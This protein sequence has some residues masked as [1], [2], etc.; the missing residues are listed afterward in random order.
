[1]RY[2]LTFNAAARAALAGNPNVEID[3]R[4]GVTPMNPTL[5]V[6][7]TAQ[8]ANGEY[9]LPLQSDGRRIFFQ[10]ARAAGGAVAAVTLQPGKY[11]L[12]TRFRGRN[13]LEGTKFFTVAE[14]VEENFDGPTIT[15]G[16]L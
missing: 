2:V 7:G 9:V 16:T 1:M 8:E 6:R 5:A 14:R 3:I 4:E 11:Q 10:E 15:V 12:L 13:P